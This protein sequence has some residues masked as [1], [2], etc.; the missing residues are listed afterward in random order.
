MNTSKFF[1]GE[2][3]I[4]QSKKRLEL[5]GEYTV[6]DVIRTG[7]LT[8]C[9]ITGQTCRRVDVGSLA[10]RLVELKVKGTNGVEIIW[11]E[12]ALR[13]K[14]EPGAMSFTEL[15]ASLKSPIGV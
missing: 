12:S 3:V 9:R 4:L 7:D 5:N 13:K 15:M 2:V 1:P 6:L 8:K 10:Y 14:H 11:N